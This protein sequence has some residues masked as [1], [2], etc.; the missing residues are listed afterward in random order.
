[1]FTW[2]EATLL[3]A[4]ASQLDEGVNCRDG[5]ELR[6]MTAG[7]AQNKNTVEVLEISDQEYQQAVDD[8]LSELGLTYAELRAQARK[9]DFVSGRARRL[10]LT[11]GNAS[12]A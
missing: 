8:A 5:G 9:G 2:K 1:M 12:R 10:W 6:E 7:R 11:I 3:V 4:E